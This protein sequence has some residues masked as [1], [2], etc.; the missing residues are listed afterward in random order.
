[1]SNGHAKEREGGGVNGAGASSGVVYGWAGISASVD[2]ADAGDASEGEGVRLV[3]LDAGADEAGYV[4]CDA[5]L[6]EGGR[7]IMLDE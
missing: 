4:C 5:L 6:V 1:L 7:S 2:E 3:R